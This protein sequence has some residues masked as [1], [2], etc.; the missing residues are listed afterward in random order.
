MADNA[1][2][3]TLRAVGA[4]LVITSFDGVVHGIEVVSGSDCTIVSPWSP[5]EAAPMVTTTSDTS[6]AMEEVDEALGACVLWRLRPESAVCIQSRRT[7]ESNNTSRSTTT[8]LRRRRGSPAAK[9]HTVKHTMT[10]TANAVRGRMNS[11]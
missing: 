1:R 4:F 9:P 10:Y 6:V 8:H 5:P 11:V 7:R 2:L 3:A